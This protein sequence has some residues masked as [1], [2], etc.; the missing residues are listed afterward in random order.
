MSGMRVGVVGDIHGSY[1]E[2]RKAVRAMGKIDHLLFTGDGYRDICRLREETG[3]FVRGVAGNCD[4]V[5][6]FPLEQTFQLDEFKILLAHGHQY[7]AKTGLS[8]LGQAGREQ[9]AALVVFGHTHQPLSTTWNEIRLL[10]PGT[11]SRER[12]Y[13]GVSYGIIETGA[14]G[15]NMYLQQL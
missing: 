10:N 15:L 1:H 5:S 3:L 2:L 8:R 11:L 6:E 7:G 12:S 4:F 9:G 14:A 13:G